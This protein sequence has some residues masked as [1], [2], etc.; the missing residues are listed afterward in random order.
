MKCRNCGNEVTPQKNFCGKCGTKVEVAPPEPVKQI[1]KCASCGENLEDGES[2]CTNCGQSV[3]PENGQSTAQIKNESDFPIKNERPAYASP[4]V[5]QMHVHTNSTS[6]F[7]G[8]NWKTVFPSGWILGLRIAAY[9]LL[10]VAVIFG[11]YLWAQYYSIT[12]SD[13]GA[14]FVFFI[15]F[16]AVGFFSVASTMVFLDLAMDVRKIRN[17]L[18]K[19]RTLNSKEKNE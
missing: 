19:M 8:L 18:E 6:E 17:Y 12:D 16:A 3:F 14:G 5:D 11:I 13:D 9:I 10:G 15:V 2:F 7:P 4:K 1:L